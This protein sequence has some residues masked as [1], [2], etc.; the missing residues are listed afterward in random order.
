MKAA[1]IA[2]H[3]HDDS[4]P[5]YSA[6]FQPSKGR[7]D[8]LVTAGGDNNIRIWKVHY[9]P[10][11][12]PQHT[13]IEYLSTLRK[14]T[15]AVNAVRFNS[16][17]TILASAGDDGLLIFWT[18]SDDIVSEFGALDDEVK[19][20]WIVKL[21]IHT[22]LEVYDICWSPDSRF[23]ATGSMD[24]SLKIY[25]ALSGV[26]LVEVTD[27]SHYV[28]GVA[29][30]PR[31]QFLATLSAD[32]ALHIYTLNSVSKEQ[33]TSFDL[34]LLA[35]SLKVELFAMNSS[36]LPD[37]S[38]QSTL[39]TEADLGST[40]TE[41][42][43]AECFTANPRNTTAFKSP[44]TLEVIDESEERPTKRFKMSLFH[45]ETLQSFFRRLAFSPD[46]NILLAPL[47]IFKKDEKVTAGSNTTSDV[48]TLNSVY[49][50]ARSGLNNGPVCHLPGLSK[51]AIAVSFN[52]FRFCRNPNRTPVFDL[53][54]KLVFA[55]ATH[56]SVIVY[57][58]ENLQPLGLLSNLHYLT[59]TDLCWDGDGKSL[60]ASSAEGF[61]SVIRF[62]EDAFGAHYHDI[63][64]MAVMS[65]H[66]GMSE[67]LPSAGSSATV[68]KSPLRK[69]QPCVAMTAQEPAINILVPRK[70][71]ATPLTS[72]SI[73]ESSSL[74]SKAMSI[75]D[76]MASPIV[77]E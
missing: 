20:S 47:G 66:N 70:K 15:Q 22:A 49:L 12:D 46:G 34:K 41:K 16:D 36:E 21:A 59:V 55:V 73:T 51:P 5:V 2:I 7:S 9:D 64:E 4:Q 37:C 1:V 17:G 76:Y 60:L 31:S 30:D 56:D 74:G 13:S 32:R 58:T 14:H 44:E 67:A 35:K 29:W 6:T 3:W 53:P 52:P 75:E 42:V 72:S 50:Y 24:N 39:Q 18:K 33:A 57:D 54:Y 45:P 38:A 43:L 28:Q 61:C 48:S 63:Q 69:E 71:L 77:L 25:D 23:I 68:E 40:K 8:R 65:M 62:D 11:G 26:K 19:E 10:N 27:H